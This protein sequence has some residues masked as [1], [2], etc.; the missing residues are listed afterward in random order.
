[1]KIPEDFYKLHKFVSLTADVIFFNVNEF[2]ITSA[3]KLKL[4]T[5]EHIWS[6]IDEQLSKSLNKV[7]KLYGRVSFIIRMILIDMEFEKVDE[8][9]QNFEFN[10][11]AAIEHVV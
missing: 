1:M 2:M 8:L 3:R 9:L 10:I 5:V 4:V 11:A 6:Q 7:I